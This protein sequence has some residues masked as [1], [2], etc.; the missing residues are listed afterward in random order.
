MAPTTRGPSRKGE[1]PTPTNQTRSH[2]T[3]CT[4]PDHAPITCAT[5]EHAITGPGIDGTITTWG[6]TSPTG[7]R[8]IRVLAEFA[9]TN[10]AGLAVLK[11]AVQAARRF[12][13]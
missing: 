8:S 2:D 9:I 4:D 12:L 11:A 7:G 10:A 6:E 13:R 3:Y 5:P 1:I